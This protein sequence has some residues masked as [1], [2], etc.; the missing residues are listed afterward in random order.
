MK[1][2]GKWGRMLTLC[3]LA[4]LILCV[5]VV[6]LVQLQILQ[7]PTLAKEA[8]KSS[9][10]IYTELASRGE[11]FDRNGTPLVTN[12]LGYAIQ[13]DYYN[14]D[15][16]VQNDVILRL[17]AL[18]DEAGLAHS[19]NLP[20]TAEPPFA[21]TYGEANSTAG[22][23]LFAFIVE[24]EWDSAIAAPA[25]FQKLCE[26]Y[27]ADESLTTAQKRTLV[28]F[29]Y[30]LDFCQFSAYNSPLTAAENVDIDT[31]ARIAELSL[32]LPGVTVQVSG[33]RE[34]QTA[35]AAHILGRVAAISPEE[36]AEKKDSGYAMTDT[37]GKSGMEQAL[38]DSL[39]GIDGSYAVEVSA[40]TGKVLNQYTVEPADP[41]DNCWLTIDLDLQKTAEDAL[42]E[43]LA[44]IKE[45]GEK[46]KN[47]EGADVE[48]GCAI[49][50]D[51][52][53]GEILALA[54]YPTYNLATFAADLQMNSLNELA[55]FYNRCIQA[56]YSPGST[57]KMCSALTALEEG[58]I[59][60]STK[61]TDRGIFTLYESYQPR[62]WLYRQYGRTHGTINVSDAIKYSCNY[63]FYQVGS[64]LG[65]DPLTRYA[66]ALGLGQK[67]GVELQ[68]ERRGNLACP[69]TRAASGGT[70]YPADTL[71]AY[72]GQGDHQ[73][74][75]IQ[76]VN[77]VATIVNGGTRYR[78]HLLKTVM[79]YKNE[80]VVRQQP[81][82]ILETIEF[83]A[84]TL[85][86]IKKG[87]RGVVT[88]DGTASSY[89]RNFPI[90][91]GGKT[92]SAQNIDRSA[93]G[94]FASFAPYDDP[95]IAVVVVGEYASSG[96]AMAPVCIAIY[97]EYFGL[98]DPEPEPPAE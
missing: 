83:S 94:V 5:L 32:E 12:A 53:S 14:W 77:Y 73:F 98:N 45:K 42:A 72:I 52:R 55:P 71:M 67:T 80:T 23:R 66:T 20:L 64:T 56:A 85:E 92:G 74:T 7:G 13:L 36:Y 17:C 50:I 18:L 95:E 6:R 84:S 29:R 65:S 16:T 19:D 51:V 33:A 34:Y 26:Y 31:V 97:N 90:E 68:G 86:A 40:E 27:G 30:Y 60:P 49:V 28:G 4:L 88:E 48:G 87:M 70:W 37:I 54:N 11:L 44:A 1:Q 2:K 8:A 82:E 59:T 24:R 61:I 22:K 47:K 35:Y 93:H 89:F 96:G 10:R 38:E 58:A 21:Y 15:K 79:D 25:F 91:V 69:E 43:T 76:L 46:D 41:G 9:T 63:F 81:P 39:R 57:F 62:C 75:P 78:P 3:G